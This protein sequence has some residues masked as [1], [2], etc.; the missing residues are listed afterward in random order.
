LTSEETQYAAALDVSAWVF[1]VGYGLESGEEVEL[2]DAVA[3][4][5][6]ESEG[7]HFF[8][9]QLTQTSDTE[10]YEILVTRQD[11]TTRSIG[12]AGN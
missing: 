4:I 5:T 9:I 2:G 12:L 11:G 1:V 10:S 6:T 7:R 8:L 3:A